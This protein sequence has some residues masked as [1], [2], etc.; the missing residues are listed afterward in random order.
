MHLYDELARAAGMCHDHRDLDHQTDHFQMDP[1]S[2]MEIRP[3]QPML[4]LT[5]YPSTPPITPNAKNI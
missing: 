1:K 2:S 3:S 5:D 4:P